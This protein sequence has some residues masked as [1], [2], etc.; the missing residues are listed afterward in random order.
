MSGNT[1]FDRDDVGVY[2]FEFLDFLFPVLIIQSTAKE[3]NLSS[4]YVCTGQIILCSAVGIHGSQRFAI[5]LSNLPVAD[6]LRMQR[7][8]V[9][10]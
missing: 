4:Y 9:I 7:I 6:K 8:E 10:L 3:Y 2:L 1:E 5:R